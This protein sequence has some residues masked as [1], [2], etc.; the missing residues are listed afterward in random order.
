MIGHVTSVITECLQVKCRSLYRVTT[1]TCL[2]KLKISENFKDVR[3]KSCKMGKVIELSWKIVLGKIVV[4][5]L[6]PYHNVVAF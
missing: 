6:W 3:E 2:E 1:D 4:E 5:I